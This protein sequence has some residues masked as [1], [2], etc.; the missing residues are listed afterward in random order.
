[1]TKSNDIVFEKLINAPADLIYRA[2]TSATAVR[3]W[4]C[5]ISTSNPEEGGWFNFAWNNGYYAS[6]HFINLVPNEAVSMA[7]IG[8]NEPNWTVVEVTINPTD[9]NDTNLVRVFHKGFGEGE[10]WNTAR[11]RIASGWELGLNNL[12]STLE[13]GV[14]LRIANRP[15]IGIYPED[16]ANLNESTQK[17]LNIP[18]NYGV[19]VTE[20]LPDYGAEKAGIQKNDVIYEIDGKKVE[21]IR[22]LTILVNTYKPGDQINVAVYRDQESIVFS[23]ETMAQ[24]LQDVPSSPEELAKA[25]EAKNFSALEALE[26]A[27]SDIS[28]IEASSSPGPEEWSAKEVL[29]HLIHDEREIHR[30]MNDL[31][32]D[33]ERFYVTW[34]GDRLFRI[35]ATLTSYPNIDS[36]IAELR[37]S[38]KETIASVAFLD[39]SFTRR[40][41]SYR[42]LA[43][44]LLGATKHIYEHIEQIK[45]NI[46]TARSQLNQ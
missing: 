3:E 14:D 26:S 13:D 19:L 32:S 11:Q 30:W 31:V 22:S 21:N 40:K 23:V 29:M 1:M 42:R 7:W 20:P 4:L 34:P 39:Q 35:R 17:S 44:E 18:I 10:A 45:N 28:E 46:M 33:Q 37:R 2:F 38:L 41:A 8:K 15:V 24:G 25:L 5:H 36:L 9:N 6:G 43:I 16:I 27:L 12:K